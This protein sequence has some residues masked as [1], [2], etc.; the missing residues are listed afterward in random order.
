VEFDSRDRLVRKAWFNADGTPFVK[1]GACVE[2]YFYDDRDN[3]I[4][5][6][7]LTETGAPTKAESSADSSNA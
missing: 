7:S 3:P 6:R 2:L 1:Y 5:R 4:L